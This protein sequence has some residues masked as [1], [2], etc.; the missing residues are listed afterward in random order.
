MIIILKKETEKKDIDI[1][2]NKIKEN[3]LEPL[4]LPGIEKIVIGAIGDER[5]LATLNLDALP[6]VERILP[7]LT[8]YKLVSRDFKHEDTIINVKGV[9]IGKEFVV[10]AGPCAVENEQQL[11]ITAKS[12]KKSGANVLRGGAYKPRSSPYSFQG[13]GVQ[14]LK[15]LKK[16]GD[17]LNLQ[18]ITEVISPETAETVA[19]Y[20]DI[21]QVGTRNMQNFD[22]LKRLGKIKKPVLLKRGMSAT[23]EEL[24]MAA[25]YIMSEGN[26][27]V[28]L[29][30]RGIR[31]FETATRNT[32]D[33]GIVPLLKQKTHL[34]VIVDPS[35]AT[36]IRAL[37]APMAKAALVAGADG[38]IIEV[39]YNPEAAKSD[40]MQSLYPDQFDALMQNLKILAKVSG[41]EMR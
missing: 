7:V 37:V 38:L 29:C 25:E 13:L 21:L 40:G 1:I 17:E 33:L 12:V 30:E 35:H 5:V 26:H 10:M 3:N 18:V 2:L 4:Y 36:G 28:I 23:V 9:N 22:L 27:N 39:H 16:V 15:L 20:A 34:P 8:P 19:E 6:F 32:L 24:L 41:K 11:T 14:G 31:T